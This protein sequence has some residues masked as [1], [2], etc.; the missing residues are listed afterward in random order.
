MLVGPT[1]QVY[2]PPSDHI[3]AHTHA[4]RAGSAGERETMDWSIASTYTINENISAELRLIRE[5]IRKGYLVSSN[6]FLHRALR[7]ESRLDS[8][9][10]GDRMWAQRSQSVIF[11]F[12]S[13]PFLEAR[14]MLP[15]HC[16]FIGVHRVWYRHSFLP[17]FFVGATVLAFTAER[18]QYR[19]FPKVRATW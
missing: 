2:L 10:T 14:S 3:L 11:F 12:M 16:Q 8:L 19:F 13:V 18:A 6:H 15:P 9:L 1:V 5:A 17:I 7:F 4:W